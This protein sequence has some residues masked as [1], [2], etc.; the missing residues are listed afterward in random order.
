MVN[1]L[2]NITYKPTEHVD[3]FLKQLRWDRNTYLRLQ[4]WVILFLFISTCFI[5]SIS[6]ILIK[7]VAG[8]ERYG[9]RTRMF[10]Q[11]ALGAIVVLDVTKQSSLKE[12]AMWASDINS[13]VTLGKD[14]KFPTILLANKGK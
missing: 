10:Y 8:T 2:F 6:N 1:D 9:Q 12:A 4:L 3:F 14:I 5:R 13:K 11:G 7:D